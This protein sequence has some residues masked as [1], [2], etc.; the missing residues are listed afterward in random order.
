MLIYAL[1]KQVGKY[2]LLHNDFLTVYV[3]YQAEVDHREV[4]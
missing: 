2:Q 1:V 3:K 4:I